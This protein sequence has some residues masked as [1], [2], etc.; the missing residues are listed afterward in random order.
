MPDPLEAELVLDTSSAMA[1]I[2]ELGSSLSDALNQAGSDAG[3]AALDQ[4]ANSMDQVSESAKSASES[5]SNLGSSLKGVEGAALLAT[6]HVG[7]MRTVV[8]GFGAA[9]IPAVAGSLALASGMG[10]LVQKGIEGQAATQRFD[11]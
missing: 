7:G 4:T 5:S 8:Q 9:A 11:A 6:G 1:Q 10:E 2:D 3:G